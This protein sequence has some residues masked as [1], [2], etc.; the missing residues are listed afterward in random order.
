MT[1]TAVVGLLGV[2]VGALLAGGVT[3][4][5]ERSKRR[6]TGMSAAVFIAGEL[7]VAIELVRGAVEARSWWANDIPNRA[8]ND[9]IANLALLDPE[10]IEKTIA[11]YG[12]IDLLNSRRSL[13]GQ[14]DDGTVQ[15]L[16][17]RLG[18]LETEKER[19]EKVSQ[20]SAGD[21][22]LRRL[23]A[24][25]LLR[26]FGRWSS[27]AVILA[28]LVLAFNI[29]FIPHNMDDPASVAAALQPKLGDNEFV[30]CNPAG[31]EWTCTEHFL[32]DTRAACDIAVS[33]PSAGALFTLVANA[34]AAA[35]PCQE[36]AR[37]VPY[38][39]SEAD[40]QLLAI[41]KTETGLGKVITAQEHKK[42]LAGLFWD[43]FKGA[44]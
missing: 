30:D 19:L 1:T 15:T 3:L 2:V 14:I 20:S 12:A 27:L 18:W 8:W 10:G 5:V 43:Y 7:A 29:L 4:Y 39:V 33:A 25:S 17:Q 37:P 26:A 41:E 11:A 24:K 42:S 13:A 44:K 36:T 22:L 9:Q 31:S 38:N 32:S 40:G 16:K 34:S 23:A 35:L 28:L 21:Q 6:A